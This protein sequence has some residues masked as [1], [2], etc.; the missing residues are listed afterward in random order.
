MPP[1]IAFWIAGLLGASVLIAAMPMHPALRVALV[2]VAFCLAVGAIV[3]FV[4]RS[5]G[6]D[7][8]PGVRSSAELAVSIDQVAK[9][10]EDF[11]D[12]SAKNEAI[13]NETLKA[14]EGAVHKAD[15]ARDSLDTRVTL[16]IENHLAATL[17]PISERVTT[18]S[19][20][21]GRLSPDE[22]GERLKW[23]AKAINDVY[24]AAKDV[25]AAQTIIPDLEFYLKDWSDEASRQ[26]ST[27][28][29]A[30][31][32]NFVNERMPATLKAVHQAKD[33]IDTTG[34]DGKTD[35]HPIE[36]QLLNL[37]SSNR[38]HLSDGEVKSW[39]R[40]QARVIHIRDQLKAYLD[41]M[42]ETLDFARNVRLKRMKPGDISF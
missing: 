3:D 10:L 40:S 37:V 1:R 7:V 41:T 38:V 42:R 36:K 34:F 19:E 35:P 6:P 2:V 26:P 5:K 8:V 33:Y 13:V 28:E 11:Q 30:A 12:R 31:R 17:G 27:Q 15:I 22:L 29:L 4:N 20:Q 23:T 32:D 9:R 14:M 18:L 16:L 21:V 25:L 39:A 24:D